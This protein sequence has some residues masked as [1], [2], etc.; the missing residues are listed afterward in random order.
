MLK[1]NKDISSWNI[2]SSNSKES[3]WEAIQA[4]ISAG[5]KSK[6]I[7]L[8]RRNRTWISM[9]ASLA[10]IFSLVFLLNQNGSQSFETAYGEREIIELPDGSKVFLNSGS[11]VQF[12]S[13][14]WEKERLVE[15]EGEAFFEVEKGQVFTVKSSN[16]LVQVLG[17]SFNVLNRNQLF[18]VSCKTGKVRVSNDEGEQMLTAG[19]RTELY[20][21]EIIKPEECNLNEIDSWVE[22][23]VYHFENIP[24]IDAFREIE[25][26][27]N[28]TINSSH[29][30]S[31]LMVDADINL[32]D[33]DE[34]L[35]VLCTS[36]GLNY[37]ETLE[38]N[39]T[40]LK[41]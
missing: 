5:E 8:F 22:N 9:A 34:S 19:L 38:N 12:N 3:S 11:S 23:G 4:K 15:L 40:V 33:L 13:A 27:Y 26:Q 14:N 39:Y 35:E 6:V 16:G 7:P 32:N 24:L 10:I 31:S 30:S 36:F 1:I 41:E 25:R 28:V 21:S 2:P 37:K 18:Q 17:T 20:D 29:I